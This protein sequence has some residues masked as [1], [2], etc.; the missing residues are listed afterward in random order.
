[1]K[2]SFC[3][4]AIV[5]SV[6]LQG[7][8]CSNAF[9]VPAVPNR[10]IRPSH[11]MTPLLS[12]STSNSSSSSNSAPN[13]ADEENDSETKKK[14]KTAAPPSIIRIYTGDD[15]QSHIE[16]TP[17]VMNPFLDIEGAHGMATAPIAAADGGIVFRTCEV[18]Y[19]LDWHTA[20]RRQYVIQLSGRVELEMGSGETVVA[21]P[22]DVVLAEDLTGQGHKTR[23]VGDEPRFYAVVPIEDD[24]NEDTEVV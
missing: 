13:N 20:P 7:R 24:L 15:N 5:A 19:N 12:T 21:G 10:A 8:H 4:H 3:L 9:V 2:K 18:G 6:F 16:R 23:V 14:K 22:G 11:L 17:L 1:M